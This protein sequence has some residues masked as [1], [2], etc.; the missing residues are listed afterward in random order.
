MQAQRIYE[1]MKR[2]YDTLMDPVARAAHDERLRSAPPE[3]AVKAFAAAAGSAST[4]KALADA[5]PV[6]QPPPEDLGAPPLSAKPFAFV[7]KDPTDPTPAAKAGLRRGDAIL[8]LGEAS[9]LREIQAELQ[10]NVG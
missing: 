4:V 6:R 7:D 2:S 10:R 8:R 9:H 1:R 5:K 3:S